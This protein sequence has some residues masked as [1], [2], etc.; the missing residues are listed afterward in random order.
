M[1]YTFI[2]RPADSQAYNAMLLVTDKFSKTV[3]ISHDKADLIGH[4][5]VS[6]EP[7]WKHSGKM[8]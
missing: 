7:F 4:Y 3:K 8:I 2:T 5:L 1:V 6:R